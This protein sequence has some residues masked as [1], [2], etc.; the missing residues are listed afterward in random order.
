M[1]FKKKIQKRVYALYLSGVYVITIASHLNLTTSDVNE[2]I[3]YL[4]EIYV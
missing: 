1:F 2:I 4:N 3:D